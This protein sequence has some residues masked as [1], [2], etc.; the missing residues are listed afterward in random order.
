LVRKGEKIQSRIIS[1]SSPQSK[2]QHLR[3]LKIA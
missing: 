1:P 2:P 3:L